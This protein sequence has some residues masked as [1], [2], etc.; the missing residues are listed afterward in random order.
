MLTYA[1]LIIQAVGTIYIFLRLATVEGASLL[2]RKKKP[3]RVLQSAFSAERSRAAPVNETAAKRP[4]EAETEDDAE[5]TGVL[6]S[7]LFRKR[8]FDLSRDVPASA[9]GGRS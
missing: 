2:T 5:E 7:E 1:L 9:K 4:V 8:G 3:K 6:A